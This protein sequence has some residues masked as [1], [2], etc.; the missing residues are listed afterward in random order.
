MDDQQPQSQAQFQ[1]P[2]VKSVGFPISSRQQDKKKKRLVI[3]MALV[4]LVIAL[5]AGVWFIL[6]TPGADE[7]LAS[8]SPEAFVESLATESTPSPISEAVDKSSLE[9]EV[10]NG[11]GISGEAAYLVSQ[12]KTLGYER[13]EAANA[14]SQDYEDTQVSFSSSLPEELREEI[15]DKLTA[16]YENVEEKTSATI[17]ID[18]RIITGLRKGATPKPFPTST[19]ESSPTASPS[20]TPTSS[21]TT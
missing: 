3:I 2:S 8:P 18:I 17:T 21:P 4:L 13:I 7:S 16:I 19:P 1:E 20:S 14:S 11:T 10:L 6:Q 15:L 5:I 12:L 9:V